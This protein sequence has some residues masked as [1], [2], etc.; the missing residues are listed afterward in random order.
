MKQN[1]KGVKGQYRQGDVMLQRVGDPISKDVNPGFFSPVNGSSIVAR[2]ETDRIVLA[3]GEMTGHSHCVL[4]KKSELFVT[5]GGKHYLN[6]PEE[7]AIE[8][9]NPDNSPTGEHD[10]INLEPGLYELTQQSEYND[11]DAW[12][13]SKSEQDRRM[14]VL[15]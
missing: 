8:H 15:D 4:D 13:K 12:D 6:V 3:E 2:D 9:I 10:V 7:S 5:R 14:D 1:Q 11:E